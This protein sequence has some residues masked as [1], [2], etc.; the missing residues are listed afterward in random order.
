MC[1]FSLSLGPPFSLG[2]LVGLIVPLLV[3]PLLGLG[4]L[5][6]SFFRQRYGRGF[7]SLSFFSR[8]LALV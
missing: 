7:L 1:I 8:C 3:V 2:L 5:S 6:L 4:G